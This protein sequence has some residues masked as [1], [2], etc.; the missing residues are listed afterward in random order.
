MP[1]LAATVRTREPRPMTRSEPDDSPDDSTDDR[2]PQPEDDQR[3][4]DVENRVVG[5]DHRISQRLERNPDRPEPL[6][7]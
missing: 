1:H 3:P 6:W 2:D 7:S 4:K 5:N